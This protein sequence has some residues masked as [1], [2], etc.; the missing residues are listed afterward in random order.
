MLVNPSLLT[1]VKT[2]LFRET[3][4]AFPGP[5]LSLT[6][7]SVAASLA[8]AP[9]EAPTKEPVTTPAPDRTAVPDTPP[10]QRM[11]APSPRRSPGVPDW[12]APY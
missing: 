5:D 9:T 3:P 7:R 8:A 11:P 1:P 6:E 2:T 12:C 4:Q 10:P